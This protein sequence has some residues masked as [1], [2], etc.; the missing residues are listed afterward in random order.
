[1]AGNGLNVAWGDP[2][3]DATEREGRGEQLLGEA[4][5]VQEQRCKE[6]DVSVESTIRLVLTQDAE[7][8]QQELD[9][10]LRLIPSM[11]GAE[12]FTSTRLPDSSASP[13]SECMASMSLQPTL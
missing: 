4:D 2:A 13:C 1:M 8:D 6:L 7:R 5:R 9:V 3:D 12:G 10:I 11:I